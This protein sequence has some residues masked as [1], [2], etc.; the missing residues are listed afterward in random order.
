MQRSTTSD[1]RIEKITDQTGPEFSLARRLGTF[2]VRPVTH[3]KLDLR[4]LGAIASCDDWLKR[5]DNSDFTHVSYGYPSGYSIWDEHPNWDMSRRLKG[6][7][8]DYSQALPLAF[9]DPLGEGYRKSQVLAHAYS[10]AMQADWLSLVS[11]SEFEKSI[12]SAGRLCSLLPRMIQWV[13]RHKYRLYDRGGFI[14]ASGYL[15][16]QWLEYRYGFMQ[17][18][19]D[20]QDICRSMKRRSGR[21]YIANSTWV[22]QRTISNTSNDTSSPVRNVQ[23]HVSCDRTDTVSAGVVVRVKPYYDITRRLGLCQ[24]LTTIWELVP[25]SFIVDWFIDVSTSLAAL[26]GRFLA[27]VA[28]SWVTV[29][30]KVHVSRLETYV[31]K[32]CYLSDP[33]RDWYNVTNGELQGAFDYER[34]V[35]VANPQFYASLPELRLRLNWKRYADAASLLRVLRR[36]AWHRS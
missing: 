5:T 20:Y 16:N 32:H 31:T 22:D 26:E 35:R 36:D 21:Y 13:K 2:C 33:P 23:N 27:D 7:P 24:P 25:F 17:F 19:Y 18:A 11:L 6:I 28:A 15:A 34:Y 30:S 14:R 10:K 3:E 4:N 29:K 1:G 12:E 9:L 8:G